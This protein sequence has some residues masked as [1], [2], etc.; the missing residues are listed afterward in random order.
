MIRKEIGSKKMYMNELLQKLRSLQN[1]KNQLIVSEHAIIRY[2][3]RVVGMNS[4]EI[5][6][7]IVPEEVANWVKI[8]GN[9]SYL[10]NNGEFRIKVKDKVVVT[11]LVDEQD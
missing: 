4:D 9:G 11:V 7:K 1:K 2:L 3:E 8:A 10:V 6:A 5:I